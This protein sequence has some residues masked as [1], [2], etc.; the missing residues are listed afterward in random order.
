MLSHFV[1]PLEAFR[2]IHQ[3]LNDAGWLVF[4]TGNFADVD[5][6]YFRLFERFQYPDHLFFFG[7]ASIRELLEGTPA[8]DDRR[9]G[10]EETVHRAVI[11]FR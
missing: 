11:A 7:A 2:T 3:T 8:A 4:E 9:R 6:R 5:A 10:E 1:D